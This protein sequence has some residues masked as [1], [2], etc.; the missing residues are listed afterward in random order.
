MVHHNKLKKFQKSTNLTLKN[1]ALRILVALLDFS[2]QI[3]FYAKFKVSQK[4]FSNSVV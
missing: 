4:H 2:C 3:G 1:N